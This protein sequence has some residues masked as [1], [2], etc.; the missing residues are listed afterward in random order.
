MKWAVLTTLVFAIAFLIVLPQDNRAARVDRPPMAGDPMLPASG[1]TIFDAPGAG[2]TALEGTGGLSIN[3]AGVVAGGYI[4]TG[5]VTHGFVRAANG[6]ITKFDAPGAGTSNKQGTFPASINTGGVVTGMFSDANNVYHGFVRT[7]TGAMSVFNAPGASLALD[8]GTIPMSINP[9]GTIT[10]SYRDSNTVYHGFVRTSVGAISSFDAPGAGA[11]YNQ[12]TY[13]MSISSTGVI[14]GYFRDANYVNHGFI[15][16]TTGKITAFDAPGA[17]SIPGQVKGLKFQG[18]DGIS[19]NTAGVVAGTYADSNYVNHGFIRAVNGTFTEF[20]A[21]GA[22]GTFAT[23]SGSINSWGG[24]AGAVHDAS[25]VFHGFLRTPDGTISE[26]DAPGAGGA[27]FLDA[28]GGISL[29]DSWVVAGLFADTNVVLHGFVYTPPAFAEGNLSPSPVSF[30]NQAIDTTSAVKTVTLTSVGL[31]SLTSVSV[32][33]TGVNATNFDETNTCPATLA[34]KKKCTISITFFPTQ[35]GTRTATLTV[36]D[37]AAD[38]PQ[39][40]TL[41]GVGVAQAVVS[42]KS[43]AFAAQSVGTTSA[44]KNVTLTNN[45]PTPLAVSGITFTGANP[46]DFAETNTCGTSVPAKSK[47]TIAVTFKPAATGTRQ[48]TMNIADNALG[49]PQT[50]SLSGTGK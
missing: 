5:N 48:A 12:G 6:T 4:T 16:A 44:P 19:V 20:D 26:F 11:G 30:G 47:C 14:V 46:G 35:T 21:P 42:P 9:A 29:N 36:S 25:G 34:P 37:N 32:S 45:L 7:A 23:V 18:T 3:S 38:S 10:G 13:P 31:A 2:T 39:T 15:R 33:I 50:V 28:T 43:L 17:G 24:V 8:A 40:V 49:S 27:G 22:A 1:F 41:T